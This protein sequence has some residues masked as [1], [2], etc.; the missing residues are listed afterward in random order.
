MTGFEG[1]AAGAGP[2]ENTLFHDEAAAKRPGSPLILSQDR[3]VI[4]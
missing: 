4:P 3:S 1:A 2:L